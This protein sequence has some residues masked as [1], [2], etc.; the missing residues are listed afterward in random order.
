VQGGTLLDAVNSRAQ[1]YG[2]IGHGGFDGDGA[3]SGAISLQTT[4]DIEIRAGLS[5]ESYAQIGHG[6]MNDNVGNN[7]GNITLFDGNRQ[8]SSHRRQ[9]SGSGGE[10]ATSMVGHG[11]INATGSHSGDITV[12]SGNEVTLLEGGRDVSFKLIGHGGRDADGDHSGSI[13][14]TAQNNIRLVG[15]IE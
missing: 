8:C 5:R 12:T 6:G 3:H 15:G 10:H 4:G 9:W 2:Q 11:G 1:N 13:R 14:V 7:T